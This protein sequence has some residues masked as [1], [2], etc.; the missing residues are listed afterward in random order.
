MLLEPGPNLESLVDSQCVRR[1][2]RPIESCSAPR[3]S[4]RAGALRA[5]AAG[6]T[7]KITRQNV[8]CFPVISPRKNVYCFGFFGRTRNA[9]R[10]DPHKSS[11][12]DRRARMFTVLD[13]TSR[14]YLY[15]QQISLRYLSCALRVEWQKAK[16]K[17]I[18]KKAN[19]KHF[20]ASRFGRFSRV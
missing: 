10:E 18:P 3:R 2:I 16:V 15:L 19:G 13:L 9:Q 14:K 20:C 6:A 1:P 17:R 8:Y 11:S 4:P 7:T 5:K 12:S